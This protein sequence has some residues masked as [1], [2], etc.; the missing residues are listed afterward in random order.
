MGMAPRLPTPPV[1]GPSPVLPAA[2]RAGAGPRTATGRGVWGQRPPSA[3]HALHL[4]AL[5]KVAPRG[6]HFFHFPG[7]EMEAETCP[8]LTV[9]GQEAARDLADGFHIHAKCSPLL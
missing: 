3:A 8:R 4:V 5:S 1:A 9:S 2:P 7:V 6:A